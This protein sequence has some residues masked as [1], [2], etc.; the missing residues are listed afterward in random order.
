MSEKLC[1]FWKNK[2]TPEVYGYSNPETAAIA[3][4]LAVGSNARYE[5]INHIVVD[6]CGLELELARAGVDR[7]TAHRLALEN[8]RQGAE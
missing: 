3:H 2:F 8:F 1:L 4:S 5:S 7:Q 6:S